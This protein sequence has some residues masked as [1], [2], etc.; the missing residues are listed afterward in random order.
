MTAKTT[1]FSGLLYYNP[2][3]NGFN[4]IV[5]ATISGPNNMDEGATAT[6]NL[7]TWGIPDLT[8]IYWRIVPSGDNLTA[9]RF[10]AGL[11]GTM[12]W[13]GSNRSHVSV[14]VSADHATSVTGQSFDII[15][16]KTL[17]G[18]A[19]ATKYG[20]NVNDTSQNAP[21][22]T[23]LLETEFNATSV[24]E[25]AALNFFV[26]TTNVADGTTLWWSNGNN[27]NG[28]GRMDHP[29][30]S[31][32]V[33]SNTG[34][35]S[36]TVSADNTTAPSQQSY[37][38]YLFAGGPAGAGGTQ[39][40][41]IGVNVNDTSQT[42]QTPTWPDP[43]GLNGGLHI[44]VYYGTWDTT[45]AWFGSH[46]TAQ[47]SITYA[48]G[49]TFG[50]PGNPFGPVTARLDGYFHCTQAGAYTFSLTSDNTAWVWLGTNV[51]TASLSNS[52]LTTGGGTVTINLVPGDFLPLLLVYTQGN[53]GPDQAGFTLYVSGPGYPSPVNS[54]AGDGHGWH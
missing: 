12:I 23:Y 51:A 15:F 6:W 41:S 13:D 26:T 1:D 11:S 28:S 36:I 24:D 38:V 22:A 40:A 10:S 53:S 8:N 32:T 37:T 42:P 46:S 14:T 45:F 9:G 4:P 29:S 30:G 21:S 31:F 47:D 44:R 16:S 33:A 17:N 3:T 49:N 48:S 25:G 34:S 27:F 54:W 18:P 2:V 7:V 19:I 20:V 35:F 52:N 39:V 5:E 43:G 50:Q